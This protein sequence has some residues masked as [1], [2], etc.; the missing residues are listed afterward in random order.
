MKGLRFKAKG[1]GLRI[2]VVR[3]VRVTNLARVESFGVRVW[4]FM[5]GFRVYGPG[6]R[7]YGL[8]FRV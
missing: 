3:N 4:C 6:S 7:V 1:F 2:F 8:G 5:L